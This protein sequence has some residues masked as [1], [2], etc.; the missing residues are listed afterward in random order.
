MLT[1][2]M[3][4]RSPETASEFERIVSG[5]SAVIPIFNSAFSWLVSGDIG[6][7]QFSPTANLIR[8]EKVQLR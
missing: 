5:D 8:F 2:N 4:D 1:K 7:D 3:T 6:M